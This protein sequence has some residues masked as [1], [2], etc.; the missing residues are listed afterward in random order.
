MKEMWLCMCVLTRTRQRNF[1]KMHFFPN[2]FDVCPNHD[3]AAILGDARMSLRFNV[4]T[5]LSS[6]DFVVVNGVDTL[7]KLLKTKK[8]FALNLSSIAH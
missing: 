6:P 5:F 8:I 7:G 2:L 1:G 4:K 3:L